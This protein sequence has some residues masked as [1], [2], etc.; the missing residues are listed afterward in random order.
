MKCLILLKSQPT[1]SRMIIGKNAEGLYA[2]LA[3]DVEAWRAF[4]ARPKEAGAMMTSS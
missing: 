1:I 3:A 4:E 2:R